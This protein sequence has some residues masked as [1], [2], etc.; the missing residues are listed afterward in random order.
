MIGPLGRAPV[1]KPFWALR[2]LRSSASCIRAQEASWRT[3]DAQYHVTVMH[4]FGR[5]A[6]VAQHSSLARSTSLSISI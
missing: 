5:I 3:T 6:S 1:G 4:K 2:H